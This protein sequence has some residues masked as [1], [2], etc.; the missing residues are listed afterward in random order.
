M[1]INLGVADTTVSYLKPRTA[2][3]GV[4]GGGGNVVNNMIAQN[5]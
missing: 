4:G 3:V 2:V 5:L 1:S